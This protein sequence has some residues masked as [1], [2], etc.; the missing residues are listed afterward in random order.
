M[1]ERRKGQR[2][3]VEA[4]KPDISGLIRYKISK[5]VYRIDR[6]TAKERRKG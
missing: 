2:R 5:G 4:E 1:K 6:R 3:Q